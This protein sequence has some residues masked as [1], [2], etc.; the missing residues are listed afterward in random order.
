MKYYFK[1]VNEGRIIDVYLFI[2]PES[3]DR[4]EEGLRNGSMT[5]DKL[6]KDV[7]VKIALPE[8]RINGLMEF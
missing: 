7:L 6:A 8:G 2:Y 1:R 3:K 4:V 5:I